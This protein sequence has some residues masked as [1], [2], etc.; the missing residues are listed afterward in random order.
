M[1][2]LQNIFTKYFKKIM[3]VDLLSATNLIIGICKG[4]CELL[5]DLLIYVQIWSVNRAL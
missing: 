3:H 2:H 5:P 4:S 1:I